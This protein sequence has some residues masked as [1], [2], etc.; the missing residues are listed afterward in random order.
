MQQKRCL[1]TFSR[2]KCFGSGFV[3]NKIEVTGGRD[4]CKD[5]C[6]G[7]QIRYRSKPCRRSFGRAMRYRAP[8]AK[9]LMMSLGIDGPNAGK[10]VIEDR[11]NVML[12]ALL[13]DAGGE[14]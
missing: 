6:G 13:I 12:F 3:E 5:D 4:Q 1:L 14:Q 9:P 11:R 2:G 7:D 8:E 10:L